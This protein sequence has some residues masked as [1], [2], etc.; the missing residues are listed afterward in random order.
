MVENTDVLHRNNKNTHVCENLNQHFYKKAVLEFSLLY[1]Y[2]THNHI[3]THTHTHTHIYMGKEGKQWH[4]SP[5]IVALKSTA[6]FGR[7]L[8][9]A[10]TPRPSSSSWLIFHTIFL[11]YDTPAGSIFFPNGIEI[12]NHPS[13]SLS[14][15]SEKKLKPLSRPLSLFYHLTMPPTSIL[16][17]HHPIAAIYITDLNTY[18]SLFQD[19][20]IEPT[21]Q[22]ISKSNLS[23]DT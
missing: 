10:Q 18:S 2:E 21:S 22:L 9:V 6:H 3:C 16:N 1:C 8:S 4:S 15:L 12:L 7:L 17:E 14:I 5:C 23:F 20:I 19:L 11:P 13:L